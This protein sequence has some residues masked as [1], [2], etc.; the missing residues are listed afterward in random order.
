MQKLPKSEVSKNKKRSPKN[1]LHKRNIKTE[2]GSYFEQVNTGGGDFVNGDKINIGIDDLIDKIEKRKSQFST[3]KELP[4]LLPYLVDRKLQED[5]LSEVFLQYKPQRPLPIVAVIYG[6]DKQAEDLFLTRLETEFIPRLLKINQTFT[7]IS[8]IQL[9]WPT[10]IQKIGDLPLKLTKEMGEEV[11]HTTDASCKEVQTALA[12]Y[13][14]PIVVTTHLL[15]DD[16]I[17]HKKGILEAL[18]DYWHQWPAL[19]SGQTLFV[20][21]FITF[22]MPEVNRI[23]QSLYS[24]RRQQIFAQLS[25]CAFHQY[26]NIIGSVLPE[27]TNI[28]Q[29]DT[30]NWARQV[31]R[32]YCDGDV[33]M[34]ALISKIRMLFD[35][36]EP[37]PMEILG[38]QLR[39]MLISSTDN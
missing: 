14:S 18:L 15:T 24:L 5:C 9:A 19:V 7:P 17:K 38:D 11:L 32:N 13:N 35:K 16:W 34:Q 28:T 6:D 22:K 29:S 39:K 30:E 20:F 26:G 21:I 2:G 3:K 4:P 12:G 8:R 25:Q 36:Q 1:T 33:E 23:M 37:I 27:L 10:D 31:A